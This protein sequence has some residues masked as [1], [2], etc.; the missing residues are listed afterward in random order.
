MNDRFTSLFRERAP[1][2]VAA[3]MELALY[4]PLLGYYST[5]R[6]RSGAAGDF[7]KSV[8]VGPLF[9]EM[10]AVQIA[11][12][13]DELASPSSTGFDLVEVGAGNGRLARDILA[14]T[15]REFPAC[16]ESLRLTLVERS[17]EARRDAGDTLRE[18][19]DHVVAIQ[20]DLPESINGVVLANELLD[21]FPVHLLT[22]TSYGLREV[23]VTS[24]GD[25]LT[26]I[27]GPL[28]DDRLGAA[29]EG[30]AIADGWRGEVS[31][32]IPQWIHRVADAIG[33][34]VLICFDYA[35]SGRGRSTLVSYVSHTAGAAR[36]IESPGQQDISTHVDLLGLRGIASQAGLEPAGCVDQTYFL[37]ALGILD[38]VPVGDDLDAV[39]RRLAARTL[40]APGGLGSTMK[41]IAFTKGVKG[42]ALRGFS[43]GR[44]T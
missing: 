28:S 27:A 37:M 35:S 9:G 8:D 2:T 43:G 3:F 10:L 36:W 38:R 31:L 5:R 20:E 15:A 44:L 39:R 40:I 29:L 14:A 4:D 33:R 16:Y 11:D 22:M 17:A 30:H 26:E 32:E 42:F 24:C 1:M 34:G 6:Q 25:G 7:F 18:H 23:Y 21:S 12:I 41:A 19:A 13:W